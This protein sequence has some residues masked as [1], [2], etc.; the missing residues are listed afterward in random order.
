MASIADL[1]F[2]CFATSMAVLSSKAKLK[3]RRLPSTKLGWHK[4]ASQ[5]SPRSWSAAQCK[6]VPPHLSLLLI[7]LKSLRSKIALHKF[8][9]PLEAPS[10]SKVL[11]NSSTAFTSVKFGWLRIDSVN[12]SGI[13]LNNATC[14]A[15]RP[16]ELF[17]LMYLKSACATRA[18]HLA[19]LRDSAAFRRASGSMRSSSFTSA[20][21]CDLPPFLPPRLGPP[22]SR[23]PAPPPFPASLPEA[24]MPMPTMSPIPGMPMPGMPMPIPPIIIID[25]GFMLDTESIIIC[26]CAATIRLYAAT[27]LGEVFIGSPTCLPSSVPVVV[28]SVVTEAAAAVWP[29]GSVAAAALAPCAPACGA[30]L[31]WLAGAPFGDAP[32]R[33]SS[34]AAW[35]MQAAAP[36]P[37]ACECGGTPG[38]GGG[39]GIA[40]VSAPCKTPAG[41]WPPGKAPGMAGGMPVMVLEMYCIPGIIPAGIPGIPPYIPGGVIPGK[42]CMPCILGAMPG[43]TPGAMPGAMF[44][45]MLDIPGTMPGIMPGAAIII[46]GATPEVMPG[47]MPGGTP[48]GMPGGMLGTTPAMVAASSA[49]NVCGYG[50]SAVAAAASACL[51]RSRMGP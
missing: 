50:A 22:G 6:A 17:L 11:P 24:P 51:A 28:A 37:L 21:P 14:K 9:C 43:V 13:F 41:I 30:W 32:L 18:R 49:G 15:V 12:S 5:T 36:R 23:P 33:A 47:G 7:T 16:S 19:S 25:V 4:M 40:A 1:Q 44:G 39:G 27:S 8:T 26:A 48:G 38:G 42:A 34:A 29:L 3:A 10:I 35:V 31:P 2:L 20:R 45:G 46:P